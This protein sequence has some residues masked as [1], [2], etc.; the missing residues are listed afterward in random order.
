MS[1]TESFSLAD[2]FAQA[3]EKQKQA[4]E[5]ALQIPYKEKRIYIEPMP[6][7][8]ADAFS[9]DVKHVLKGKR[10]ERFM[11]ARKVFCF[12]AMQMGW[13]ALEI[14]RKFDMERTSIS[15]HHDNLKDM[16]WGW[17]DEYQLSFLQVVNK[18]YQI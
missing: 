3:A 17:P 10:H 2:Q 8:I 13:T 9:V 11:A 15:R 4:I 1:C 6:Q 7:V 14:S 16:I 5:K 12:L 18:Y